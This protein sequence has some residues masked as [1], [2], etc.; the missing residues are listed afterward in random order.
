MIYQIAKRIVPPIIKL[1][2]KNSNGL[3]NVPK[4]DVFIIVANHSRQIDGPLVIYLIVKNL[5]KKVHFL[6]RPRFWF[7]GETI[8][9]KWV[10]CIPLFDSKVAYN[11]MKKYLKERKI[12]GIFPEGNIDAKKKNLKTGAVRLAI[13]T[14]TPILPIG[15]NSSYVPFSSTMRIGK[16]IYLKNGKSDIEKMG[17]NIMKK[18][19]NLK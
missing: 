4:N 6:A 10:G 14:N 3:Q 17:T 8:C 2:V 11:E 5:N 7:L 1:W 15:I 16:L 18:V 12:I 13:E 19:Y 9:R